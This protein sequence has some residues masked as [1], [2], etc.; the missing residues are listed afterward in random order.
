ATPVLSTPAAP[1]TTSTTS[2]T[3]AAPATSAPP[4]APALVRSWTPSRRVLQVTAPTRS[5]LVVNEDF[6]A[7]WQARLGS[8]RL[9]AVRI[10]GWKQAWLLPA[11]TAGTVVLTY[12]PGAGYRDAIVGGLGT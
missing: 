2:A 4:A 6:N 7:G 12:A 10:D 11:G 5:Y 3:F 1:A 8:A 9:R